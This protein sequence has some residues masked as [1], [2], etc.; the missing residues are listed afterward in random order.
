MTT[1]IRRAWRAV[2]EASTNYNIDQLK[3][4]PYD[5]V[6]KGGTVLD[7]GSSQGAGRYAFSRGGRPAGSFRYIGLD[8]ERVAGVAVVG[9]AMALP[10]RP[11]SIDLLLCVSVLEYIARP[12]AFIAE[13]ERVLKPGGYL[14]LSAPF[15]FPHHP[16]PADLHRFSADGLRAL[17]GAFRELNAG[18]NRGPASTFTLLLVQF[19]AIVFS[20]DSRTRYGIGLKIF[21]WA[22]CWLKYLDRFIGHYAVGSALHGSAFF[23]GQKPHRVA[24]TP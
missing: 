21:G 3:V 9:D 19:F 7:V 22:F 11:A 5:F 13:V 10:F 15:V 16:P 20:G 4:D 24:V 2:P 17:A 23:F 8:V 6:E 14:Y 1:W 12:Q 18:S